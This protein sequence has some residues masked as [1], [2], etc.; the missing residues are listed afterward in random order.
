MGFEVS[1][2]LEITPSDLHGRQI[3]VQLL[4]EEREDPLS[5]R[6]IVRLRVPYLGYGPVDPDR[7]EETEEP[8]PF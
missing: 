3:R 2:M 5:G 6:R 4:T 1:G 8:S 7:A